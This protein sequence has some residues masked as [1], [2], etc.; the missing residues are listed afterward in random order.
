MPVWN[1]RVKSNGA[2]LIQRMGARKNLE[3]GPVCDHPLR[4]PWLF[5]GLKLRPYMV[6]TLPLF[7][8]LG[9]LWIWNWT[10][11]HG[12]LRASVVAVICCIQLLGIGYGVWKNQYRNEYLSA[13]TFMKQHGQPGSLIMAGGEFGFE[14]G[15]DGRVLDDVRLG[16]RTGK[17]PEFYVQD[18]W[19]TNWLEKS[20]KRNPAVYRHIQDTLAQSYQEVHRNPGYTIY[21]LR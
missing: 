18:Y 5:E 8:G 2:P 21:Q 16:Y 9:A 6:H 13:A 4:T 7:A 12:F 20:A 17:K 1:V 15:F 19:Y 3:V 10:E 11:G 14:F